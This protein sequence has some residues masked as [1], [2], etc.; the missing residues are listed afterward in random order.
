MKIQHDYKDWIIQELIDWAETFNN[1]YPDYME[2]IIDEENA[3]YKSIHKLVG[4]LKDNS[5]SKK[6]YE[7]IIFHMWQKSH[8]QVSTTN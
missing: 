3:V 4:K 6:D 2:E 8:S 5:C 1:K 7:N